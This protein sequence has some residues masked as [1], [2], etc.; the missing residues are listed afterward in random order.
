MRPLFTFGLVVSYVSLIP[1]AHAAIGEGLVLSAHQ[2]RCVALVGL[3]GAAMQVTAGLIALVRAIL[4]T[5]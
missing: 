2:W 5:R 3:I 1:V 4:R